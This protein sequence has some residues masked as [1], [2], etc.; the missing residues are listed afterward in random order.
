MKMC[1][2]FPPLLNCYEKQQHQ[3]KEQIHVNMKY[4]KSSAIQ[5]DLNRKAV[6][7]K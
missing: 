4:T 1:L 3:T 6:R 2:S 5:A 7:L